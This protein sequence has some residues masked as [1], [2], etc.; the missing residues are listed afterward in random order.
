MVTYR[1]L[2]LSLLV[3]CRACPRCEASSGNSR[4]GN[5]P[6]AG[7]PAPWRLGARR[8]AEWRPRRRPAPRRVGRRQTGWQIG[9]VAHVPTTPI[10]VGMEPIR[11]VEAPTADVAARIEVVAAGAYAFSA[12]LRQESRPAPT[13]SAPQVVLPIST[14][15]IAAGSACHYA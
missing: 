6:T 11:P 7:P 14:G 2:P 15:A 10:V 9:H 1:R 8:V 12:T 4:H 5:G 13:Q 3:C